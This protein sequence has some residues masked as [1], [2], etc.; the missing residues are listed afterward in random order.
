MPLLP[1]SGSG[2]LRRLAMSAMCGVT[3]RMA[4]GGR[5]QVDGVAEGTAGVMP[6]EMAARR[7][8]RDPVF[9]LC[10]GRSGSTLLRFLLDA[11][12]DL[13]CPPETSMPALCSQ[14]AVVWSLIEGAPLAAERGDAPP[15]VPDAAVKGIRNMLDEMTGSYLDRRGKRLFCDKSLGSARHADLLKQIYPRARFVCLYRHPMDM[16]RSGLEA[17]PFGLTGYG[18][19]AYIAGSPGNAVLALA[20]Y[21]LENATLIAGVEE[22]H[23]DMCH[24]VRYEDLVEDPEGVMLGVY[25]FLGV[26]PA[27]GVAQACF[28]GERERFGPADHKI[29]ATSAVS[30]DS[31][32]RGEW[33][34]AGMIAPPITAAINELA[35]KLGYRPVDEDWG[36]PGCPA[37]P[38]DPATVKG[39]PSAPGVVPAGASVPGSVELERWLRSRLEGAGEQVASRWES[40]AAAK[41]QVV[42]RTVTAGNEAQWVV[43]VSARTVTPDDGSDEDVAWS[44]L[45]SPD[46]WQ[47]IRAGRLNLAAA[48][49]RAD[50]RY[51]A[52][53]DSDAAG[54]DRALLPQTRAAMLCDLLGLSSWRSPAAEPRDA[55]ALADPVDA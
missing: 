41:F 54:E 7:E 48:L 20:R 45:A 21:W 47:A 10:M 55:V 4:H 32:G 16:I 19:D 14:L 30:G 15:Q 27:P 6:A 26:G 22:A 18:F 8:R 46:T 31:V 33:V 43:D 36:S 44:M 3:E 49:R 53:D 37:D 25:A 24:R 51:S 1:S 42:S 50:L 13:A 38:R 40:C 23:P 34:P 5:V 52:A 2:G 39:A 29:W 12:P 9:V 11:H 17:C 28:S 35:G